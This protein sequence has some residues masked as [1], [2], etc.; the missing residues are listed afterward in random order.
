MIVL[1]ILL[2]VLLLIAL[3][4]M[5]NVRFTVKYGEKTY[6]SLG[7]LCFNY[8]LTAKSK[9]KSSE[10]QKKNEDS[11]N[12]S[13]PAKKKGM[14]DEFKEGLEISD[15]IELLRK[16]I[17]R[18]S[19]VSRGHVKVKI[20]RLEV[21]VADRYPDIAALKF[22]A[23]NGAVAL[24]I[25]YLLANTCLYPLEKSSLFVRCDFDKENTEA[26][27]DVVTKVRVAHLLVFILKFFFDFIQ[28]KESKNNTSLKG[29][30]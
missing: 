20:K 14:L 24:L 2:G 9:K 3:L 22:G 30:K 21:V 15:F 5:L 26:V 13:K 23:V 11:S 10:K 8:R 18:L 17:S 28:L 12:K 7:V 19:E 27:A 25:E 16:L 1:Y 4:L 6:A 29:T